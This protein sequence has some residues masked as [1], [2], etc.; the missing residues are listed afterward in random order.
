VGT[1]GLYRS[2]NIVGYLQDIL[3][4]KFAD[5]LG[6]IEANLLDLPAKY[7][8]LGGGLRARASDD[9]EAMGLLLK[10][11]YVT[12]ISVP[13]DVER[14]L[15][16]RA[17]IGALGDMQAYMQFKAARA[18]GDAAQAGGGV[19]GS[20]AGLGVGLG[21]GMG[22]GTAMAS[23]I[24]QSMQTAMGTAP[25][26]GGAASVGDGGLE[27]GFANLR[28][29]VAQQLT[30]SPEEREKARAALDELFRQLASS[31]STM[32]DVKAARQAL[33]EE[34]PWLT[35]PVK[36]LLNTPAAL[37]ML[38]QIAARSM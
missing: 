37:Q 35:E 10:S 16:E 7:D 17:Q 13:E 24:G 34:F 3:V 6:E 5:L 9:F 28:N 25:P 33:R 12:S 8:E 15:D 2:E 22:L 1:Q 20:V 26:A 14:A 29:L 21:A 32:E 4:S 36:T 23:A 19:E 38:G 18:L 27:H 31:T 11:V 30:L